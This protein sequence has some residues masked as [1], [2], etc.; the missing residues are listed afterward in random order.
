MNYT[1][2]AQSGRLVTVEFDFGNGETLTKKMDL[3]PVGYDVFDEEGRPTLMFKDP[4]NDIDGFFRDY[5]NAYLRGKEQKSVP[6]LTLNE[7][8]DLEVSGE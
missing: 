8:V 1:I 7:P 3:Q 6:V 5:M 4:F 2:K